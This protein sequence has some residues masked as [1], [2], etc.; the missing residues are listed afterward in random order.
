MKLAEALSERA[1]LQKRIAQL[2]GRLKDNSKIQEGDVPAENP[3]DLY[4]ELDKNLRQLETLM[5]RIN[6]TNMHVCVDGTSLT[7]LL[8]QKDVLTM[9]VS[10]LREVLKYASSTEERYGRNEIRYIRNIDIAARQKEID[11]CS[12]QLRLLD[13]KIQQLNWTIDLE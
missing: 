5:F 7:R 12:R 1:D 6:K 4:Q 10:I 8:A 3:E 13:M 9:R 2:K 11:T